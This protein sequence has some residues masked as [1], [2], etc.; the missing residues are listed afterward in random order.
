MRLRT[1]FLWTMVGAFAIAASLGIIAVLVDGLG[2][3]GERVLATSLLVGGFSLACLVCAFVLDRRKARAA[4]WF[5]IVLSLA[6][7][8]LWLVVVWF[9]PYRWADPWDEFMLKLGLTLTTGSLWCVHFGLLVLPMMQR[10]AW[11][12]VRVATMVIAALL[13]LQLLFAMWADSFN[14][15]TEK[16]V[17]V[18]AILG[19]CGTVVTPVLALIERLQQRGQ[20]GALTERVRVSVVCPRCQRSQH[21]AIGKHPCAGCGL[22]ITIDVEEPRCTCGYLLYQLEGEQCP[23]CGRAIPERDRWAKPSE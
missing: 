20:T 9:D 11:R 23:E 17:A 4:M 5:G 19:S 15:V 12:I 14:D 7:L 21:L 22:Q 10:R 2:S 6:A 13:A 18:L 8:L 3:T 16:T 1:T